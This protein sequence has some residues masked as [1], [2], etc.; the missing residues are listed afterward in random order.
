MTLTGRTIA[1]ASGVCVT[2]AAC[3]ACA[4]TAVMHADYPVPLRLEIRATSP[5]GGPLRGVAV[6]FWDG[7]MRIPIGATDTGGLLAVEHTLIWGFRVGEK[8]PP[9]PRFSL[10]L[11]QADCAPVVLTKTVRKPAGLERQTVPVDV[12]VPCNAGGSQRSKGE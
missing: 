8:N 6:D 3:A 7:L 9:Q 1:L 2:V 12:V 11:R 4:S 10:L 5:E